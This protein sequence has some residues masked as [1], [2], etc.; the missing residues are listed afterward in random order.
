[1]KTRTE[2]NGEEREAKLYIFFSADSSSHDDYDENERI[3]FFFLFV[4]VIHYTVCT[5]EED[6]SF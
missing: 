2:S 5:L 1:M 4:K 6:H 3:P